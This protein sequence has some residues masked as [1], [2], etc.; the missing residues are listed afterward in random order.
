[1]QIE[2]E[3]VEPIGF[4]WVIVRDLDRPFTRWL[5]DTEKATHTGGGARLRAPGEAFERKLAWAHAVAMHLRS[6]GQTADYAG[7]PD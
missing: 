5:L 6:A 1:M 7:R 4:A 2:H 3:T